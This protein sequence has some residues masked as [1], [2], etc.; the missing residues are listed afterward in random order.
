MKRDLIKIFPSINNAI[1][2]HTPVILIPAPPSAKPVGCGIYL[3]TQKSRYLISAGHLLNIQDWRG[4]IVPSGG[5]KVLNLKGVLA[6]TF[7]E[8][9][10]SDDVD[11]SLFKFSPRMN[12]HFDD[13]QWKFITPEQIITNHVIDDEGYYFIA[14]YP[15]S[16][17]K[18]VSGKAEFRPIP[19]KFITETVDQKTYEKFDFDRDNF[20]LVKYQRRVLPLNSNLRQIT[21]ELKGISGSGLWHV[22][23][24]NDMDE[25]GVP[26][27]YLVGIMTEN[28]KDKGFLVAIKIDF[29]TELIIQLFQ[30]I[31]FEHTRF[32]I[33]EKLRE[34][35]IDH[36]L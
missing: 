36:D 25:N 17:V 31:S 19:V 6:T 26:K 4:L 21:K 35:I 14:G 5:T 29:V 11:F 13:Q 32:N 27:Y 12:K 23:D 9:N 34:I 3:K 20:I 7:Q 33:T 28:H 22:P 1:L 15:V 24:F 2:N 18:K 16:G 30:D 8:G 10:Q